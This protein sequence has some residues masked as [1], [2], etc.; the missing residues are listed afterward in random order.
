MKKYISLAASLAIFAVTACTTNTPTTENPTPVASATNQPTNANTPASSTP[1]ATNQP[2]PAKSTPVNAEG[3]QDYKSA[4]GK[5]TVKVPSK[6]EEKSQ[7][8]T[9][10]VGKIQLNMV[11]AEANDSGYFVGYADFPNKIADPADIQK[12]LSDSVKGSVA[13]LKGE[14]T[15]EK[16]SALGDVPCRDFEAKGKVKTTNVLMKGRFCL[17]GNRLYQV[18]SLGAAEKIAIADVDRFIGSFKLEK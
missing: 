10:S 11:I 18:F 17:A 4:T 16:I 8:Q 7:E 13:N 14:I 15:S 9:T 3:W 5:F 12:G 6:P 1:A 2:T